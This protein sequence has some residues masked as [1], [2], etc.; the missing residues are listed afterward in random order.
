MPKASRGHKPA[1]NSKKKARRPGFQPVAVASPRPGSE[2]ATLRAPAGA[3]SMAAAAAPWTRRSIGAGAARRRFSDS[4]ADYW[5]V[6]S[7][8]RRIGLLAGSLV[9]LLVG[10]SFVIR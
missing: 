8:L 9:V 10:L 2:T 3:P 5:Y 7:D 1:A 4:I 6:A